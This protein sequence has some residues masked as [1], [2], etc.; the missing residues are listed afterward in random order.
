[1]IFGYLNST[2]TI[3]FNVDPFQDLEIYEC[4]D[5]SFLVIVLM[6]ITY[7]VA[8]SSSLMGYHNIE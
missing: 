4:T 8:Y 2:T 5:N 7:S 6:V 3:F 1:M